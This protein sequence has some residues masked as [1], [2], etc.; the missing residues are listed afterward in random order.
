MKI[1]IDGRFLAP[2]P[3]GNGVLSQMLI[4]HLAAMETEHNFVVYLTR[5]FDLIQKERFR[6][7]EMNWLHR[8]PHARF[9]FTFSSELKKNP[10]D[11]FHAIYT[12][13]FNIPSKVVLSLIEFFWITE[14]ELFPGNQ[15]KRYQYTLMTHYGVRKAER[16]IVPTNYV[17]KRL[18]ETFKIKEAKVDVVPLGVNPYYLDRLPKKEI[19]RVLK[20]HAITPPYVLFVGNLH[21]RKNVER[22]IQCY[23]RIQKEERLP[24][25]LVLAGEKVWRYGQII[26]KVNTSPYRENIRMTGYISLNDLRAIYQGANLFVFPSL[27][28]GFGIPPLEAMASSVPVAAANA[29]S[30]PDVVGDSAILFDP[31]D[32]S[33]MKKAIMEGLQN[34]SLR[35]ILIERGNQRVKEYSWAESAR[36]TVRIYEDI[37]L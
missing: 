26:N 2:K 23:N 31:L 24:V 4:T 25:K 18:M 1:G 33:D 16:I 12:V 37:E 30:I 5:K 28:E 32:L 6:L 22:L 7:K 21:P 35:S 20:K 17:R 19:D 8:N 14:P 27:E 9:L 29:S 36:K 11:I 15:L 3:S 34:S 13:P 10:V